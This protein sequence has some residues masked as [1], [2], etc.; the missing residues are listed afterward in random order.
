M[1]RLSGEKSRAGALAEV[2]TLVDTAKLSLQ[3]IQ[4]GLNMTENAYL[5]LL[6]ED[7]AH[8]FQRFDLDVRQ[9]DHAVPGDPPA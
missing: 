2:L 4:S 6:Q 8:G 7:E 5:Q 1:V 9:S 3:G